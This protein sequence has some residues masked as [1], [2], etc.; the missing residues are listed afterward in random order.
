MNEPVIVFGPKMLK[1]ALDVVHNTKLC[2]SCG[3][4]EDYKLH[5]EDN[6]IASQPIIDKDQLDD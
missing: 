6:L 3:R 5:D 1:F 4:P 2:S